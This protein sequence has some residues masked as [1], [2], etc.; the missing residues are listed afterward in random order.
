METHYFAFDWFAEC[1]E[2]WV[3]VCVWSPWFDDEFPFASGSSSQSGDESSSSDSQSPVSNQNSVELF[4]ETELLENARQFPNFPENC[5][6]PSDIECRTIETHTFYYQTGEDA[7]C[8]VNTGFKCRD[9][10]GCRDHEIRFLCCKRVYY[11]TCDTSPAPTFTPAPGTTTE[12]TPSETT[13]T[14]GTQSPHA[15]LHPN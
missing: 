4:Q 7:I 2:K 9:P 10:L 6:F 12:T 15:T 13:Q 5:V 3:N 8:D 14:P 11:V 1:V